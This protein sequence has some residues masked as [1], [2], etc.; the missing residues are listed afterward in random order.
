MTQNRLRVS[1][2]GIAG[3][4]LM[5]PLG[6]RRRVRELLDCH[7]IRYWVIDAPGNPHRPLFAL[8]VLAQSETMGNISLY[9]ARPA[10][11]V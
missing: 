8:P 9:A 3:P 7:A 4:F 5:I 11:S 10:L 1:S 6:Q 2:D